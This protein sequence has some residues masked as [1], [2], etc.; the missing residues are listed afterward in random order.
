MLGFSPLGVNGA[1]YLVS[2]RAE[3]VYFSSAVD[4]LGGSKVPLLRLWGVQSIARPTRR[5][6]SVRSRRFTG[7]GACH[8]S[9]CRAGAVGVELR[10]LRVLFS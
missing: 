5:A 4:T 10:D 3:T 9:T 8:A 7:V 2:S 1:K 6:R